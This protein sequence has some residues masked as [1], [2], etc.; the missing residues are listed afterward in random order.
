[1]L[2]DG[3]KLDDEEMGIKRTFYFKTFTKAL[4]KGELRAFTAPAD[5]A[6][7]SLTL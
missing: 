1:L 3:W 6:R 2:E 7:T 5:T 4:V